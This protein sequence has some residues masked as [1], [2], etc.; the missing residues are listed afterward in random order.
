VPT[1]PTPASDFVRAQLQHAIET[2]RVQLSLLT[3]IGTVLVVADAATVGY[4][5][6]Q[7]LAGALWVGLVF[8]VA[9]LLVMRLV[10]RLTIP[11]LATAVS[12]EN[13]YGEHNV[14][15]LM[16]TF[17]GVTVSHEFLEQI[18]SAALLPTEPARLKALAKLSRPYLFAGG[19]P[20][21]RLLQLVI[22]GQAI[23]PPVLWRWAGWDLLAK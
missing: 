12:I 16:S 9:I 13:K 5:L 14:C 21:R 4:G 1:T 23:C 3:Q 10:T 20:T 19:Q 7:K 11:V 18:R 6:Q 22:V 2:Y 15:G 8:P 17:L